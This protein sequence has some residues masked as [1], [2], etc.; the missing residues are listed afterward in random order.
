MINKYLAELLKT[1]NRVIIP[2]FGAFMVK[3]D[4]ETKEKQISFNDFLKYND[5][6]LV[7]YIAKTEGII[8]DAALKKIKTY[9]DSIHAELKS[10]KPF[11][12]ADIGYLYKDPRGNIRFKTS[13]EEGKKTKTVKA[14]DSKNIVLE[15]KVDPKAT[16][17]DLKAPQKTINDKMS[18]EKTQVKRGVPKASVSTANN[19]AS[20]TTKKT[21]DKKP[22]KTVSSDKKSSASTIIIV[23]AIVV[24]LGA[25]AMVTYLKWDSVS[26]WF[27]KT[28]KPKPKVTVVDS[29]AIKAEQ[30]RQDSIKQAKIIADSIKQAKL[31]SIEKQKKLEESMPK[32]YLVAGSFQQKK[33]A[34]KF[35][36][37]LNAQ[38]YQSKIFMER[39]GYYRVCYSSFVDRRQA[40][41]EYR[42][43]K[44]QNIEVWVIRH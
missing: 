19:S 2:D 23:A 33:N 44:N 17:K 36:D 28:E 9:V 41:N 6:L 40:F 31:D 11:K 22:I 21:V 15:N 27:G 10:G 8:K 30:M 7:N 16:D 39:R 34:D 5:G 29:A 37:K 20:T 38:G 12:L 42:K 4:A 3:T 13:L 24:V 35:V 25:A 14:D 43:L 18:S 26:G 1:N 32:Y